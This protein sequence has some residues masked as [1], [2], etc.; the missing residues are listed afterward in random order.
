MHHAGKSRIF[1]TTIAVFWIF[2][3]K[4]SF[5]MDRQYTIHKYMTPRERGIHTV[6]NINKAIDDGFSADM[7]L[8]AEALQER[9]LTRIAEEIAGRKGTRIV[10]IAGPSSSGKTSSSKRLC[11]Q[12]IASKRHPVALSTDNWY[13][14]R[15]D[16]PRDEHGEY[17]FES[18]HAMDLER[19][20]ADLLD[21]LSGKEVPLPT[22]NFAEGKR[23]YRGERLRLGKD[24]I[25]VIEGIHALNP[26][27][28]GR[29][30]AESKYKVFA[31]PMSPVSL[32]GKRWI[33][34]T[35]N[36]LLRRIS[37]DSQT[38]GRSARETIA[39]WNSVRKG[40]K[41]WVL[42]F[43]KEADA[44]FDT[45][46]V[47]ELAALRNKAEGVLR[48]VPK[49]AREYRVARMLLDF[50]GRFHPI[51]DKQIPCSSLL[52]EFIGNSIFNVG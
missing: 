10:L 24:T 46:M 6:T 40:E 42:P 18:I 19:F 21:L 43:E 30:P 52:R 45:S 4:N 28:T 13:V 29:I 50:L 48:E 35:V 38:R 14:N 11:I 16:A 7:I 3:I 37:R 25:L 33:P 31:A 22:Y 34:T 1:V 9:Q 51:D 20:N 36:R 32:D 15:E 26:M 27:L 17:D 2:D 47:Y 44:T 12:L 5:D 39:C 8:V 23:E 49:D 41:K